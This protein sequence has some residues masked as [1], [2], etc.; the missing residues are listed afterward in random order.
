MIKILGLIIGCLLC[1]FSVV[2]FIKYEKDSDKAESLTIGFI[3]FVIIKL[4]LK[5]F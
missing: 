2:K 5:Y 3:G 4:V 1:L